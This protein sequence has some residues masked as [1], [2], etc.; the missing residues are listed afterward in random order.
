MITPRHTVQLC[1][2][3]RLLIGL[4]AALINTAFELYDTVVVIVT[5]KHKKDLG[6]A[7]HIEM[8]LNKKLLLLD[9]EEVL[10]QFMLEDWP[11]ELQFIQTMETI[12][13]SDCPAGRVRVI[14][15]LAG[16]LCAEGKAGAAIRV[17]EL[18]NILVTRHRCSAMCV[19]GVCLV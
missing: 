10:S 1:Q 5:Q 17:E 14:N 18:W 11:E 7:L 2:D 4:V 6:I 3:E 15:E 9:A 13:F 16:V 19:S 12:L 8:L